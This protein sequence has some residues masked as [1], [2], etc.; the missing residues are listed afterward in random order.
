MLAEY[1]ATSGESEKI[2]G[3]VEK[4]EKLGTINK[5]VIISKLRGYLP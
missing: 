5:D 2:S 4:A 1:Y 3:L